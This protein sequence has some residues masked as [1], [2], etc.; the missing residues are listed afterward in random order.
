MQHLYYVPHSA[1]QGKLK[2]D[3]ASAC[4]TAQR[5]IN[6]SIVA[7]EQQHSGGTGRADSHGDKNYTQQVF[8]LP[9]T[10]LIGCDLFQ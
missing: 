4:M 2:I 5:D 10:R 3:C 8:E 7:C 6:I 9:G 1:L